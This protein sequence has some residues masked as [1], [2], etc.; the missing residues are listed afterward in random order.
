M[1]AP[2]DKWD[3]DSSPLTDQDRAKIL[4]RI[5]SALF[6]LGKFIPEEEIIEGEKVPL[7]D[8]IFNF[9]SKEHP[10]DE[11]VLEA[12]SLADAMQRKARSLETSLKSEGNLTKGQ[13]HML[14]DEICGLMRA[15]DEIRTSRGADAHLKARALM[16]RVQD[17]KR[18]Q[19]FVKSVGVV[20][21]LSH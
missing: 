5:H 10:S 2:E 11:E 15:V 4:A 3:L 8:I 1:S 6:W 20:G 14:L 16:S 21:E 7:R 9:V 12:L 13:A 17:E 18:W 19:E